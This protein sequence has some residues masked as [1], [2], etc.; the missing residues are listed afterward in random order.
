MKILITGGTGQVAR[1]VAEALARDHEVWCLG[2]FRDPAVERE[3]RARGIRTYRWD[4]AHGQ[5]NGL[6]GLPNNF[7]HVLH[8]AAHRG[9]G[10]DFEAA[11]SINSTAVGRLMTHCRAAKAFLFVSTGAVYARAARDH[12]HAETDPLGG[13]TPW[14]PTYPVGKLAAEGAV[15]AY[16]TT[17]QLPATIARLNVAYGPH[18]HGGVPVL[19]FERMLAGESVGVPP[20][21][22]IWCN[23]I[24]TDDI[25]RQLPALWDAA[26][27][28]A[29]VVNWG[30]DD[31]V[32]TR[33]LMAYASKLTG[34]PT[35]L[36]HS[37]A[38]RETCAFDN[39]LRRALI[40]DCA[41]DWR[42]GLRRTLAARF[43][44]LVHRLP[45]EARS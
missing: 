4:M 23:P 7:T 22:D 16:A 31:V 36:T 44:D 6:T 2:R 5:G 17:L 37:D 11:M 45:Q 21:G 14:L 41:V 9:T 43:P 28:P 24:H 39:T 15:R 30:G 25:A 26:T 35:R 12:R 8:A 42:E 32:S 20:D 27:V 29:R 13:H 19:M 18:G 10:H 40:G 38:C 3:L 1:P 33:R 34:V